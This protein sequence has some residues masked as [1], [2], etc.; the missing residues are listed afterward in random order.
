[1]H[2]VHPT[3]WLSRGITPFL[4]LP[5]S[6][7]Y[8]IGY[9]LRRLFIRPVKL[10]IPVI[11]IGNVVA[12]GAGKTPCA[13][14]IGGWF[15]AR[16]FNACYLSKGFGGNLCGPVWVDPAVH[17]AAEVG[18]EALL[19]AKV[20]PTLISRCRAKGAK[21]AET[22]GYGLIIMDDGFQNPAIKPDFSF[23]VVDAAYGF[24][25]GMT[26][27]AGPLREPPALAFSRAHAIIA[28]DRRGF[29]LPDLDLPAHI[30]VLQAM[31]KTHCPGLAEDIPVIAFS[32][33][34]RPE[35][36]FGSLEY[37][38]ID[39]VST[40]SFPDHHAFTKSDWKELTTTAEIQGAKLVT[41]TK[42]AVRLSPKQREQVIIAE[43]ELAWQDEALITGIL[44]PF[45]AKKH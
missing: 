3:F 12:G 20:L 27:P 16:R 40:F 13:L 42:D 5:L 11:C 1:M 8:Q 2:L 23:L 38:G 35:K 14:A 41:T 34:A 28:L 43:L 7:L 36:F 6:L 10:S 44:S 29:R 45:A 31:L 26:L 18:D 24:G 19:L 25:N 15:K 30:P 17:T 33:I 39:V 22:D 21:K 37:L 4:L 9:Q 32:G